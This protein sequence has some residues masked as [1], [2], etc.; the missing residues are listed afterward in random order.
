MTFMRAALMAAECFQRGHGKLEVGVIAESG[1]DQRLAKYSEVRGHLA[2]MVVGPVDQTSF[3]L[4]A[5]DRHGA[6]ASRPARPVGANRLLVG[7][8]P[9]AA[10][11]EQNRGDD[12][13]I[14]PHGA[15]FA[16]VT[17]GGRATNRKVHVAVI[18]S[19]STSHAFFMVRRRCSRA[20]G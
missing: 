6:F 2:G 1:F 12:N 13:V 4:P 8:G 7:R 14:P 9:A 15:L 10:C 18:R 16:R 11:T 19:P 5:P 3:N 20:A 17:A